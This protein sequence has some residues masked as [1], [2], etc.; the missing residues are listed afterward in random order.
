M[1]WIPGPPLTTVRTSTVLSNGKN[2]RFERGTPWYVHRGLRGKGETRQAGHGRVRAGL[3]ALAASF[4]LVV[5]GFGLVACGGGNE[6]QDADE[7]ER[8]YPV[9]IVTSEFPTRQRLAER[10]QLRIGVRNTGDR[11]IPDLAVTISLAGPEGRNSLEP[12]SIR[13]NDERLA[14][15]DRPVW[16]LEAGFPQLAGAKEAAGATTANAK[17]FAFDELPPGKTLSAVWEVTPVRAGDWRLTYQVDAGLYGN[18]RAETADGQRPIGSFA[19]RISDVPPQ[20]RVDGQGNV[21]PIPAGAGN[22]TTGRPSNA[23]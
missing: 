2:R 15:P 12:F 5:S 20:T 6:R 23:N 16:I 13:V 22:A 3:A 11:P 10:T 9:E 1:A 7:V 8:T 14:V 19:V 18:A 17:T 4:V 21:V